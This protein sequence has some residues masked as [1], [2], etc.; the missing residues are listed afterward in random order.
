MAV[1]LGP[2][3]ALEAVLVGPLL[4]HPVGGAQAVHP[5]DRRA[6]AQPRAGLQGDVVVGGREGAAAQVEVLVAPELEHRHLGLVEVGAGLEHDDLHAALG[7][8]A[9]DHAAAGAR[10]DHHGVGLEGQLVAVGDDRARSAA[11]RGRGPR[12]ARGSRSA[13]QVGFCPG[14]GV[15]ERV[16]EE[17]RAADQGADPGR[18]FGAREGDL[19]HQ[20]F[21]ARRGRGRR[22]P[23][24]RGPRAGRS[25]PPAG[26]R[27][28]V[29]QFGEGDVGADARR[30]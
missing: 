20:L 25:C 12:S 2:V 14:L 18:L 29:E 19:D 10:A 23:G 11:G 7:Q 22:S 13:F 1:V 21:A 8:R 24:R 6:A 16:G 5:V 17:D 27:G 4:A 28:G 3:D 26:P 30:R 15:G 9:G